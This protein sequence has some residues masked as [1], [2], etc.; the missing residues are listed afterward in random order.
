[1]ITYIIYAFA[2]T[3]PWV[4]VSLFLLYCVFTIVVGMKWK[5]L[6]FSVRLMTL[7]IIVTPIIIAGL[8]YG[9]IWFDHSSD[10][11]QRSDY[12]GGCKVEE[13]IN[14]DCIFDSVRWEHANYYP[15]VTEDD[16]I[17]E[18]LAGHDKTELLKTAERELER[19]RVGKYKGQDEQIARIQSFIDILQPQYGEG[20]TK[21]EPPQETIVDTASLELYG[22][23]IGMQ[24]TEDIDT[25]G[26]N[27]ESSKEIA[28]SFKYPRGSTIL[29]ERN[30][31]RVEYGLGFVI[32][33]LPIE[34]DARCGARTGVGALPDNT[35]VTDRLMI[36]GRE[37]LAPGFQA[38]MDTKGEVFYKPETRYFYDFH[39]MLDVDYCSE[40]CL[41]IGYGIYKELPAPLR[42]ADVDKTMDALRA[43]VESLKYEK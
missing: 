4:A 10:I 29:K 32:F 31:Y 11:I 43:I 41:R 12:M 26:W 1:M 35:D 33:L 19:L 42:K 15:S 28:F 27:I 5:K 18:R 23:R 20:V 21:E 30:C 16:G 2:L 9:V 8:I 13:L 14:G 7:S 34:G 36:Q 3:Y 22:S 39:H 38:I 24:G 17:W 25:S 40:R 37:Y 6:S